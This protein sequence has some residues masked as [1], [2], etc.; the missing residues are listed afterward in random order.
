MLEF[1]PPFGWH[2]VDSPTLQRIRE[3]LKNFES[4]TWAEILN[5]GGK[6]NHFIPVKDLCKEAR[7]RLQTIKQDDVDEIL[8]L[9]L[10]GRERIFG[11]LENS[12]LRLLW[13]D[14]KHSVCPS[15]KKHT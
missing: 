11:I 2:E 6:R 12:V 8:S 1:G 14:P 15:A 5:E 10:T 7:D 9:G 13:W 4:M 3:R